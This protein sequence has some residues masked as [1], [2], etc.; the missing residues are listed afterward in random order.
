MKTKR[1]G[2]IKISSNGSSNLVVNYKKGKGAK[3]TSKTDSGMNSNMI[4]QINKVKELVNENKLKISTATQRIDKIIKNKGEVENIKT[5]EHKNK[6]HRLNEAAQKKFN[7][8]KEKEEA[9]RRQK[10]ISDLDSQ[11][12]NM[13]QQYDKNKSKDPSVNREQKKKLDERVAELEKQMKDFQDGKNDSDT[14][15]SDSHVM[16]LLE[17]QNK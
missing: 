17:K 12:F 16:S 9:K 1:I 2:N 10:K 13:K 5:V 4:D 6:T 3:T 15:I 11:I 7:E 14:E 8:T